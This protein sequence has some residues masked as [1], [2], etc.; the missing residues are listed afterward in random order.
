MVA[1]RDLSVAASRVR[2]LQDAAHQTVVSFGG[3]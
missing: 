1:G 2:L 3:K